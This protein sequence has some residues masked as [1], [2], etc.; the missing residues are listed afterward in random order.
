M[1]T[2]RVWMKVNETYAHQVNLL[3][4]DFT[5]EATTAASRTEAKRLGLDAFFEEY[6]GA[7]GLIV[8]LDGKSKMVRSAIKGSRNFAEYRA[9][10][11]AAL[12]GA[13]K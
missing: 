3:V 11:D 4:L 8:I 13:S 2:K 10:I 6:S 7:T 1:L 5:N 12:Q 9:G